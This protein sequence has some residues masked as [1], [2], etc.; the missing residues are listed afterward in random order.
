MIRTQIYLTDEERRSLGELSE[1]SGRSQSALIREAIDTYLADQI[2]LSK[3][4]ILEAAAGMWR[5][6]TDLPDFDELRSSWD[7]DFGL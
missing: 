5:N 3:A 6:R 2:V 7:R 4:E 1:R